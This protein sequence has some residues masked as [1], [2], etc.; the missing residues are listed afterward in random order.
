MDENHE[1]RGLYRV[2]DGRAR[3]EF[4]VLRSEEGEWFPSSI[5]LETPWY[6]AGSLVPAGLWRYCGMT[7]L[8]SDDELKKDT[9]LAAD[10][11]DSSLMRPAAA[12]LI[13]GRGGM[14]FKQEEDFRQWALWGRAE[15]SSC[16]AL[17]V[18]QCLI[19][20]EEEVGDDS[21]F[22]GERPRSEEPVHISAGDLRW[23]RS[24]SAFRMRAA[25]SL[26]RYR[27][28]ACSLLPGW[29]FYFER[30]EF[31]SRIWYNSSSWTG[32]RLEEADWHWIWDNS[33]RLHLP[34]QTVLNGDVSGGV[35]RDGFL[36]GQFG[37]SWEMSPGPMEMKFDFDLKASREEQSRE[38]SYGGQIYFYHRNWREGL[39]GEISFD[40][41][42]PT[43][44]SVGT[45]LKRSPRTGRYDK[46]D[47]LFR[48][49]PGIFIVRPA[50]ESS[51]PLGPFCIQIVL[52]YNMIYTEQAVTTDEEEPFACRI[53]GEWRCP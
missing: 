26:S 53:S 16:F 35:E 17:E 9:E 31:L 13:P 14:L 43:G 8:L 28:P 5:F 48:A 37:I 3:S 15:S 34:G 29:R 33:L 19:V 39:K 41:S 36:S 20:P 38:H 10:R 2:Q 1:G 46:L 52:S 30:G 44:W 49:E 45:G 42:E 32:C 51:L 23:E 27:K 40:E 24:D 21:W 50:A 18:G 22:P 7:G 47:C 6:Q 4:Q 11:S 25:A 12:L